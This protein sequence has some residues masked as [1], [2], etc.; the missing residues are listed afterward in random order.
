MSAVGGRA[1][2]APVAGGAKA[3]PK[4]DGKTIEQVYVKKTQLEHILLRPDS[5]VGSLQ[6]HTGPMYIW[7][8]EGGAAAGRIV[9]A[10]ITY[11]PGLYKIFDEILVNAA[12]NRMRDAKMNMLKVTVDAA[13]GK[14]AVWNNGESG[15]GAD[16]MGGRRERDVPRQRR[17]RVSS[18]WRRA[19]AR[20]GA[21]RTPACSPRPAQVPACPSSCTRSTTSTS[22]S[23]SSA[24]C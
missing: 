11:V 13:A 17:R 20:R 14:L 18:V 2:L 6:K 23:S 5:Y 22:P 1:P 3:A 19:R 7:E 24:T 9:S 10:P 12:D 21:G 15:V 16:E 8:A 4:G